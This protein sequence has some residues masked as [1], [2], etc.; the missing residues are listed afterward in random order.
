MHQIDQEGREGCIRT[1]LFLEILTIMKVRSAVKKMC[2]HCQ[3]VKR[4]GRVYII[5]SANPKHKQR[6][7]FFT[8]AYEGPEPQRS[9]MFSVT[10]GTTMLSQNHPG[11]PMLIYKNNVASVTPWWR[12]FG[13]T[14]LFKF[15]DKL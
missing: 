6:Q 9:S 11:L 7:G 14:S 5:C 10:E 2:A 8:Y 1:V 12:R 15:A 4:R 3:T 13:L